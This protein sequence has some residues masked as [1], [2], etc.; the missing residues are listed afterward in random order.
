MEATFS[1]TEANFVTPL[2]I[3]SGLQ[4]RVTKLKG[5]ACHS[6]VSVVWPGTV[7]KVYQPGER[8]VPTSRGSARHQLYVS[9][10]V[11]GL[12]CPEEALGF[13]IYGDTHLELGRLLFYPFGW[14][15][16]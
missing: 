13:Q 3:E 10:E 8:E 6:A 5:A 4:I 7:I 1:Q 12:C 9:L 16:K 2:E 11:T 15:L 14:C